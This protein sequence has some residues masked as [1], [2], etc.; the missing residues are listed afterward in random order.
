MLEKALS[1]ISFCKIKATKCKH[2]CLKEVNEKAIYNARYRYWTKGYEERVTWFSDKYA[3]A[4]DRETK[5]KFMIDAGK[6]V[7]GVCFRNLY[8]M[9]KNFYARQLK[10]YEVGAV[11]AGYR[12]P[13]SNTDM[14]QV[15]VRWLKDYA[16]FC[17]DRMPDRDIVLLPYRTRKIDI[18]Q[19]Y[20][21]ELTEAMQKTL[22]R[23]TF[24]AMW[25]QSFP[26]LK[27]KQVIMNLL[28]MVYMYLTDLKR[29]IEKII[30]YCI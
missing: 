21:D 20:H 12:T 29:R 6:V 26:H 19:Q 30:K 13:R 24:Y 22:C 18:F 5:I 17:G 28:V 1:S 23:S 25:K 2:K 16:T 9:D 27:I 11:A 14:S 7:C 10:K 8:R 3:E 15:A 4:I